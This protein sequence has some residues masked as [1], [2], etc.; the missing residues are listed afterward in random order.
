MISKFMQTLKNVYALWK[1]RHKLAEKR[2]P[3]DL[4]SFLPPSL[5][6]MEKPPHPAQ[7][8]RAHV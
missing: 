5:E 8:G 4:K 3:V 2:L 6:V 1:D 7:I